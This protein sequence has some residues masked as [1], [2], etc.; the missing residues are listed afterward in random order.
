MRYKLNSIDKREGAVERLREFIRS[1]YATTTELARQ[2]GV[3]AAALSVL[4][5]SEGRDPEGQRRISWGLPEL[6]GNRA[7]PGKPG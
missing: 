6:R 7:E 5:T 1:N 2:L 3:K 4:Q